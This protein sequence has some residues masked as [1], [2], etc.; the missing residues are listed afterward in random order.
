[1]PSK[2]DFFIGEALMGEAPD[3]AHLDVMIGSKQGPVGFAFAQSLSQPSKGHGSLLAVIRPNLCPKPQTIII[4]KVTIANLDQANKIFGPAQAAVAK[5]VADCVDEGVIPESKLDDWVIIVN[6]F[7]HPEAKDYRRIYQYNY[8]ATKLAIRRALDNYPPLKKIL[9]DKD[10]AKHPVA[11]IKVPK[12][13]RPPYLQVALDHP[14]M[15]HQAKVIKQLPSSDR[16]ILEVGTPFLKKYGMDAIKQVR[17]LAPN[18]YI[19]ADLKTLDVGKLEVDDA[20]KATADGV[21]VSGLASP[22]SI[23]KFLLEAERM[24]IDGIIDMMEVEDPVA[25]L[26]RLKQIPRVVI[27]HRG[28][29]SEQSVSVSGSDEAQRKK[30][31]LVPMIK[32][33]YKNDKL[34][35]GK[36]RVLVAVAGGISP[37][38][39]FNAVHVGADILIVGRYITSSKDVKNSTRRIINILPGYSD[40]DLKRIHEED[41]DDEALQKQLE[42]NNSTHKIQ[43]KKLLE[44]KKIVR[45]VQ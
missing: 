12:L 37:E 17:E 29:D 32:E 25:K 24:G 43:K 45:D 33:L 15:E 40:I 16:I 3:L 8:G 39:A 34:L 31:G 18:K 41:D 13:W 11:G 7:I 30:W 20:F 42:D 14:S 23:D 10:R 6:V 2:N 5:A 19:V 22:S 44:E 9:Y 36:D 4:P 27:L 21:V 26:K 35:S 1:M 38:T 28:I